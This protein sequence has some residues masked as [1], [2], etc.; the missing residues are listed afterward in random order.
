MAFGL[1][2]LVAL[3]WLSIV[4]D[5]D[6]RGS[7]GFRRVFTPV[8]GGGFCT[9]AL[10]SAALYMRERQRRDLWSLILSG[11]ST[12]SVLAETIVFLFVPLHGPW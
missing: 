2:V 3:F 8:F 6:G 7:L 12:L 10:T 5:H 4:L 11:I 9:L 1:A